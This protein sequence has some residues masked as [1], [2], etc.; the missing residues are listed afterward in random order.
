MNEAEDVG[1]VDGAMTLGVLAAH[2]ADQLMTPLDD[3]H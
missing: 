1:V 2:D 3:V